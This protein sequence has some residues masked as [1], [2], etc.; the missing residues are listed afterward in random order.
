MAMDLQKE[1]ADRGM[2][3]P[4][5]SRDDRIL[6]RKIVSKRTG[7]S[8]RTMRLI[9]FSAL[10]PAVFAGT[11]FAQ[12]PALPA[13]QAQFS[14]VQAND[15]K[16]AGSAECTVNAAPGGYQIESHGDLKMPK[17]TYTFT[18]DNRVDSQLN[19]VRDQLSGTVNGAQVTFDLNSDP[20]GH[21]FQVSIVASGKTTTNSFDR[22]QNTALLPDLDP[23]AY[24]AMA[25][26]ALA[27][28]P[29]TW[30]VIP[31]QN[32]LLIPAEYQ[33][34][35][36]VRGTLH[37]QPVDAHHTTVTISEENGFTVEIY[38]TGQGALLEADLPEQNF[39]VV[40]NDFRLQSRPHYAPPRGQAPPP[41]EGQPGQGAPQQPGQPPPPE[42]MLQ[43]H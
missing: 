36:D 3:V 40:R 29:T 21:Q 25:H 10:V 38:Y 31:K 19:I 43:R 15:G 7:R 8:V 27:H 35:P 26:F 4:D 39:Y 17:F 24:V 5:L 37:G 34:Q 20:T 11:L 23:A 30:I 16:T 1:G 2:G 28:P 22:H 41:G 9:H 6:C 18:N 33:A 42:A 14:I 13:G 32:G 12:A